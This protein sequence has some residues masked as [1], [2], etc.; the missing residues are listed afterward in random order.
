MM[1]HVPRR[2][3]GNSSWIEAN[4]LTIISAFLWRFRFSN[5]WDKVEIIWLLLAST[6]LLT[7]ALLS[8]CWIFILFP[9]SRPFAYLKYKI[10]RYQ[11]LYFFALIGFDHKVSGLWVWTFTF[12]HGYGM[13]LQAFKLL[14]VCGRLTCRRVC[15]L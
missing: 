8:S 15:Y 12:R 5:S 2:S 9:I 6:T 4:L 13:K 3:D 1:H 14:T 10:K 11:W 7:L